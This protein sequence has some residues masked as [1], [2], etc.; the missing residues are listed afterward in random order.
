[1]PII[2]QI[3]ERFAQLIFER[4]ERAITK[5]TPKNASTP[6]AQLRGKLVRRNISALGEKKT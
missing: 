2:G 1:M 6:R 4:A 5:N 3:G